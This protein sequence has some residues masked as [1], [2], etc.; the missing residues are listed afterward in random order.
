MHT[1]SNA[2][3]SRI[4][5]VVHD[6]VHSRR[7]WNA[8]NGST[9]CVFLNSVSALILGMSTRSDA[10]LDIERLIIDRACSA[11]EFL[12]LLATIPSEFSGD[13][14]MIRED[15]TGYLSASG[16]GGDRVI[17]FF[18]PDDLRF[19]LEAHRLVNDNES[20]RLTA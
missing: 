19:Y 17:Y 9:H 15:S 10:D 16:R 3:S 8:M 20:L 2:A 1:N 6:P 12:H 4:S 11:D 13:I 5:V 18:A 14:L 7:R